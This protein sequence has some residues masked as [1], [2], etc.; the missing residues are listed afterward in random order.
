M[1]R[2]FQLVASDLAIAFLFAVP[3]FAQSVDDIV[4]KNLQ[5]KGGLD[6]LRETNS[7]KMT[8]TFKSL[9]PSE[10]TMPMT[11]WAKRP[12]LV[13]QEAEVTP[14]PG[15][16]PPG[17]PAGPTKM[18]R[19]AD[20]TNVWMQQGSSAPR[21]LPS[22]QA[23]QMMQDSEFDSVFVDYRNK[24]VTIELVG[25]EKLGGKD[26]YHLKVSRRNGPL[27]HYFLDALTGLEAKVS[28]EASQGGTTATVDTELSDY[29]EVEGRMVPFKTRQL[30]NGQLA[31]E[32]TIDS[33][34]FNVPMADTLFKMPAK[35]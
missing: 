22:A 24:G 5:A 32:M 14:P 19:A 29:R 11:T 23:A 2:S 35:Q 31:A 6:L 25:V 4:A 17:M 1:R 26:V 30:V 10:M 7:V 34:E 20:G 12:N 9:Q 27:Q 13:R 8:G 3:A 18:I 28:T 21:A 16:A 15:Q 33:V